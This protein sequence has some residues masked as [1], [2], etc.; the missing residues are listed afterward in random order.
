MAALQP[1]HVL[2]RHAAEQPDAQLLQLRSHPPAHHG[3]HPVKDDPL[4]PS[5]RH[6]IQ[7]SL[8]LCRQRQAGSPGV[9]HQNH[10]R[11]RDAPHV[12]GAGAKRGA[13]QPV[14]IPHDSLDQRKLLPRRAAH[15]QFLK[16]RVIQKKA[17]QIFTLHP[18]HAPVEHG[19]DVVRAAFKCSQFKAAGLKRRQKPAG[20]DR[21][22]AAT[23]RRGQQDAFNL[24]CLLPGK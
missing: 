21:L 15:K 7:K 8:H 11:L 2:L 9:H 4:D 20:D 3:I 5:I 10:R 1:E 13:S 6:K 22:S 14:K 18:Q 17:V 16:P 24:H 19:I 12:P 23:F